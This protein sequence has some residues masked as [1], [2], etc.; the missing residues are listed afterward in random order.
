[1]RSDIKARLRRITA[2]PVRPD[3]NSAQ[4]HALGPGWAAPG[5]E[6]IALAVAGD[7][8]GAERPERADEQ[9]AASAAAEHAAG[10][11]QRAAGEHAG[12]AVVHPLPGRAACSSR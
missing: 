8:R 3:D 7:A 5:L 9:D 2:S 12:S 6:R 10:P 4:R 11:A 1:M